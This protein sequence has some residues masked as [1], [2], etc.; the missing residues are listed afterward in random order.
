MIMAGGTG[1]HIFPGLAVAEELARDGWRIVWMGRPGA[2]ESE[3]VPPHG[4]EMAWVDFRGVRQKGLA[5]R[6]MTPWHL[7]RSVIRA[8]VLFRHHKPDVA[9]GMGGYISFPGS[10]AAKLCGVPLLIHEQNSV[11][12]LVNRTVAKIASRMFSGFPGALKGAHWVGNPVRA[13]IAALPLPEERMARRAGPLRVLV[14]GGSLGAH[15]L[16]EV[17]P[18]AIALLPAHQRPQI[19]HQ[20]GKAH[21]AALNEAYAKVGVTANVCAFIDD[22]A[23][24]YG[25]ADLVIARAGAL[26][27]AEMA[28]AGVSSLLVP[29]PHATDDHQTAN[30]RFFVEKGAAFWIP[31]SALSADGLCAQLAALQRDDLCATA[32]KA[33]GLS[34][35]NAAVELA[36]A[37][38]EIRRARVEGGAA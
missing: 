10:L 14:M 6:V 29:Y 22:M 27:L 9:L 28:A 37:C 36:R 24:A 38:Q 7:L 35:P 26:T 5:A 8:V 23:F 12:G 4:H 11:A 21:L 17:L 18:A 20:S 16:N 25:W 19:W 30:A 34:R 15:A 33:R 31:Q 1:G 3:L 13:T 32:S 2:M